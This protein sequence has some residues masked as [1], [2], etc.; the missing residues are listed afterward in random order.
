MKYQNTFGDFKRNRKEVEKCITTYKWAKWIIQI[1]IAK[2]TRRSSIYGDAIVRTQFNFLQE[3][4]LA[5][6]YRL[7]TKPISSNWY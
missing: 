4:T 3:H 1:F 7:G 6:K 2:V 5:N